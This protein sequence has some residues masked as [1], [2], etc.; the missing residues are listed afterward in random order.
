MWPQMNFDP[1]S[2]GFAYGF[3]QIRASRNVLDTH[4]VDTHAVDTSVVDTNAVDT[5]VVDTYS[6][7]W[8]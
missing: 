1:G 3:E 7:T 6:L 4:V 5:S 8:C 2:I